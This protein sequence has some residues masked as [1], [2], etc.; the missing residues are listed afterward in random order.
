MNQMTEMETP[1]T[2]TKKSSFSSSVKAIPSTVDSWLPTMDKSLDKYFDSHMAA[3]IQEWGLI[4]EPYLDELEHRLA[5]VHTDLLKL[6]K[7]RTRLEKRAEDLDAGIR[8][9]EGA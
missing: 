4:T 5:V 9:L 8:E 1:T 2:T 7:G 6:E 3:I